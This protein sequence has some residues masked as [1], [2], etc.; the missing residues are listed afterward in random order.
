MNAYVLLALCGFYAAVNGAKTAV[1]VEAESWAW[2]GALAAI[3][4]AAAAYALWV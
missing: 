2:A 1:I 3:A 4:C